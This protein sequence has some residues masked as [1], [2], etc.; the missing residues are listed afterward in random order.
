LATDGSRSEDALGV[1]ARPSVSVCG[2]HVDDRSTQISRSGNAVVRPK[3]LARDLGGRRKLSRRVQCKGKAGHGCRSDGRDCDVASD[4]GSGH[5]GDAGLCK[6]GV[7]AGGSKVDRELIIK[8]L[9]CRFTSRTAA[10]R[11]TG[12]H[13]GRCT[14]QK[15]R[16]C[17]YTGNRTRCFTGRLLPLYRWRQTGEGAWQSAGRC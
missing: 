6:D 1:I 16:G 5:G 2:L 3:G 10:R 17:A 14:G 9:T 8:S 4:I 7:V 11:G 13:T 15:A 12:N